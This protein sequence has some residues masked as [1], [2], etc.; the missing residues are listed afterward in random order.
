MFRA[1]S[2]GEGG[3]TDRSDT[4]CWLLPADLSKVSC[5][6]ETSPSKAW[7]RK[8]GREEGEPSDRG[9]HGLEKSLC[10]W[11]PNHKSSGP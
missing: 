5:E 11:T 9:P 2:S 10:F 4:V 6:E 8:D 1:R 7:S 3:Q